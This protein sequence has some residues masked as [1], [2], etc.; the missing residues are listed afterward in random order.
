MSEHHR[1]FEFLTTARA[2]TLDCGAMVTRI[3]EGGGLTDDISQEETSPELE[4]AALMVTG[5]TV[6]IAGGDFDFA[7]EQVW[8]GLARAHV[9]VMDDL[10]EWA[11]AREEEENDEE[12][13][14]V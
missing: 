11:T 2:F 8:P 1:D 10:L 3:L 7:R 9:R 14:H 13:T 5:L 12:A 4:S 6:A